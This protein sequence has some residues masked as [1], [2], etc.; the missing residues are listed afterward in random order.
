MIRL[1][2]ILFLSVLS[3]AMVSISYGQARSGPASDADKA[4]NTFQYT[5]AAELYK[6][7]Y[8]KVKRNPVEKR[9]I[10]FRMAECYTMSGILNKAKQQYLRLEKVNYQKD[11]PV[12]FLRLADIFRIEKNYPSALKY[13][14]KYQ[15]AKPEDPRSAG[16]I[17]ACKV[18]PEWIN[19]PTR[20][21][22]ENFKRFNSPLSE[23]SPSWGVPNKQ[24]Q[25][26]FTSSREGSSGKKEDVWSGQSFSDFYVS[27][28]PKSKIIDFPGEWTTPVLFDDAGII[29]SDANEGESSFNPKGTTIYFTRCLDE[30]KTVSFCKIYQ[31]VKK[32]RSWAEPELI[33]LGPDSFDYVHPIITDDELTLYFVSDITGSIGGYDI[34]KTTRSKKNKPFGP[35]ENLG[36]NINS[37]DHEMFPTLVND[38]S[39]YFASKG[40][41]GLGG[42]DIFVSHKK[43]DGWTKAENLKYPINSEADDYGIIFDNSTVLDPVSGFPFIEKGYFSSN[44]AG[45]R[46]QDDIWTFKL[47]PLMFTLSGFVKDSVT[48]QFVDGA[49]VTIIGS[50]GTS[51]KTKTDIRG[52]YSFDKTKIV[53]NTTYDISVQKSGYYENENSKGRETT[54]GL[55]E[56]KDLKHDFIINPIPK[57]PVVLPD[58]LYELA[59]WD[60]LPQYQDSLLGLYQIMK[61]NPT[62]VIELRSHTDVRPIPMTNDTLSQRRAESCVLFLVDS[63]G[64]DPQRLVAKGYGE[65]IPRKLERD[66]VSRGITFTKGTVL[67]P[68]YIKSLPKNQQEAAHDLNRR[69]EFLILRDDYVP[70]TTVSDVGSQG[71]VQIMTQKYIPAEIKEGKAKATCYVNSKTLKFILE[72]NSDTIKISYDQAMRYLK[73][74]IFTV[75]D[76]DLKESAINEK[77]GTII[78][79]AIV[80]FRTLQIGDEMIE[81]VEAKV[82][83]GQ[84]DALII[85]SNVFIEEFGK[86]RLDEKEQKLIFE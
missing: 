9:R 23:W 14:E 50:D 16:R 43:G 27:N 71:R 11:N 12:I 20:H 63:L 28:K 17:E 58:I 56:N 49:T 22:V 80:F 74:A 55:T 34:W 41:V 37:Y 82:V 60:L 46:G 75:G 69:T 78:D 59:K 68:E 10:M 76:F 8:G 38:T 3:L 40:H 31:A 18:A 47:R 53:I 1:C 33:T 70:S 29:N 30:K 7:A 52:Y 84:K 83:K 42:Y 86:Y 81:N 6:K 39:L 5:L 19:N 45:G 44:R 21:E 85:G 13:Y 65:R 26:V 61:D 24:N 51:Y 72:P 77:D 48:R 73:E 54:V 62:L 15:L 79:G 36:S 57:D 32:G 67:T 64:I 4:F 66:I 25:I 35:I 2:K